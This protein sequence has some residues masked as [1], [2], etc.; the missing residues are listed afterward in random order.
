MIKH[1]ALKLIAY[2]SRFTAPHRE[3]LV[4]SL[5][6][7]TAS[8]ELKKGEYVELAPIKGVCG[9]FKLSGN[10]LPT[11][12]YTV[13]HKPM[14]EFVEVTVEVSSP[15]RIHFIARVDSKHTDDPKAHGLEL[16]VTDKFKEPFS[17]LA[18]HL[19]SYFPLTKDC[20]VK[21]YDDCR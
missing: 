9:P 1:L 10:S 11:F 8:L 20:G 2:L 12:K 19:Y 14:M 13:F 7:N 18:L 5:I 4:L 15:E 21:T 6:L 3:D 16:P 17:R